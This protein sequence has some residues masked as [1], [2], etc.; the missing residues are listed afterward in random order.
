MEFEYTLDNI[1]LAA[2]FVINNLNANT[3]ILLD[4]DMGAGKT[5]LTKAICKHLGVAESI[6]SPTFSIVN[7]YRDVNNLPIYH[8]DFYRIKDIDEALG[9]GVE[10]YFYSGH[11][12]LIEW[13]S[14]VEKIIPNQFI[15]VSLT[16]E[17]EKSR[18]IEITYGR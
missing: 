4:G 5:T 2:N 18:K 6:S 15:L 17:S 9:I 7:E 13:A 11:F 16:I 3:V 8:F 10:D 1:E 12:C 14:R